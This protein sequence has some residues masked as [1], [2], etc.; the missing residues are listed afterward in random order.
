MSGEHRLIIRRGAVAAIVAGFMLG[1]GGLAHAAGG[2]PGAT[3][4]V[5]P[6]VVAASAAGGNAGWS[7]GPATYGTTTQSDVPVTMADGTVISTDVISPTTNG[8]VAPGPFPVLLTM[9]PYGKSVLGADQVLPTHGYI[10]VV[11]DIRGTGTSTGTFGLFDPAQTADAVQLVNWAAK[12][13]HSDGKVG[14]FGASYLGIDQLLTAAAVGKNSPL[15]AIFPVVAADDLYRDTSFMGGIPDFEFDSAYLGA[16]MPAVNVT[17]PL[18]DAVQ[19]PGNLSADLTTEISR[20]ANVVGYNEAFLAGAELGNADAYDGAYWQARDPQAVLA[21]IV[22]NGIPAYLVG[23][24]Y[25]LFQRGEPLNY[26]GLQNA[27]DGRPTG[28]PMVPGQPVTGRYQLLDGPWTHLQG[29][30]ANLDPLELEWFD[31]WLKGADTGMDRTPTPLHYY[32]LGT[33]NYAETTTY[34]FTGATPTTLYFGAGTLSTTPPAS[35]G[36]DTEVWSPVGSP[37]GRSTDQWA[38]G[39]LTLPTDVTGIPIPACIDD[40]RTT[41]LGPTALTYTTAPLAS[42]E[43]IA[44]PIGATLY[45]SATTTD[46]QFVVELE[47]VA[48]DGT[49]TPLTEGALL[50]QFRQ[51]DPAAS[52]PGANG[53]YLMPFHPYTQASATPVTPGA[54]T[55]YDVEVFPTDD[56]VA[57]GHR[58][59]VTVSTVDFPH[60]LPT[61]AELPAL[62]GGVYTVQRTPAAPSSI[63]LPLIPG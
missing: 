27:F 14:L 13:P 8:A 23:G 46:T 42:P 60:L 53:T 62:L 40:D 43:T 54:V 12:L 16:L 28:A 41:A 45:A 38:M 10:E 18:I 63:T 59:R 47:D 33:G 32:D 49:S 39:A 24:E 57:P 15:K 17:N 22:A 1:T 26:A 61:A 25:D 11:A 19:N 37:C 20:V 9:T 56:T 29:A 36:A 52:W 35:G 30:L 44:G 51:V 2:A 5:P 48:P 7:E 4:S 55:R 34:P 21:N 31:T 6:D 3:S 50:G 58:I